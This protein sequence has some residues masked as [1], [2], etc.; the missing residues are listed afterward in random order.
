[1]AFA[2][3]V[4]TMGLALAMT[5]LAIYIVETRGYPAWLL[6]VVL[7][8]A[9]LGQSV[10]S[11][12]AGNLSDRIGRRPLIIG[13]LVLRSVFITALGTQ[14][15]FDAPLWSLAVNM[16]I[17]S[18]L[19]GCFEPVAY[20]LVAD[21]V[22]ADQRVAAFAIQ[23]MGVNLG[24]AIG[25]ALGGTLTLVMPYGAVFYVAAAG[26]VVAAVVCLRV[27]DP[28]KQQ[29]EQHASDLR[30]ALA[31]SWRTP[32]M[33]LLLAGTF[34]AA[35]LQTQMFSV[36]SVYM[37]DEIGLTKADVGLLYA[38]NGGGVLCLQVAA[39]AFVRRFGIATVLPWSS[40]L[41]ALGFAL[42]GLA[43]GM[44]GGAIAMIT[45]T[46]AEV[47]F[48]P[49]HQTAVSEVADPLHR[50]RAFGV[51]GFAQ[52]VGIAIAPLAGGILYDAMG[53]HHVAM[54]AA[55]G[56]IGVVQAVCFAAFV[57]KV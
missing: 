16:A 15:I 28:I 50:G 26:L 39:I 56:C 30:S 14:I 27:V 12:W 32:R 38:I 1:M 22:T 8:V 35:L 2:R 10:S 42:I 41:D 44:P 19:R 33:R 13:S 40:L 20:A 53:H 52:M 34:L 25:P 24:W 29:H 21:V 31:A 45:I 4:N 18:A 7:L 9:N 6:G 57:R 49:A 46:A 11:A 51:V 17:N 54:W 37:T 47:V 48:A 5:F 43:T 3:A 23:R 36:F 55:I